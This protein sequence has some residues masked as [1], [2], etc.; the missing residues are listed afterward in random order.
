MI[1]RNIKYKVM[2]RI[3][4][5]GDDNIYTNTMYE[6]P[7]PG[8]N[9]N[10]ACK[11]RFNLQGNLGNLVLSQN[12]RMVVETCCIPSLT[13]MAG[14]Y[15]LLR[16][17]SPTNDKYWD[18]KKGANGN[19]IILSMGLSSV[20]NALNILYNASEF[21]Y[22]INVPANIFSNG[23]IDMELEIPSQTASGIEFITSSPLSTFYINFVIIDEDPELTHDTTLAPPIDY[24]TYNLNYS[25][26]QY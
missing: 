21:F 6:Y 13:N 9:V 2:T 1:D 17:V 10:N 12:A 26:K 19:P 18:S 3:Q 8:S 16:L 25:I 22:N 4:L 15:A 11:M 24:K 14:K 5:Y 20:T 23:I 7:L